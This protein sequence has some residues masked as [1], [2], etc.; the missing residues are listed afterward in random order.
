MMLR[1]QDLEQDSL[2]K[3]DN[4]LCVVSHAALNG[5]APPAPR[6]Y[7][8]TQHPK[9]PTIHG[10]IADSGVV[11][12][13]YRFCVSYRRVFSCS[14]IVRIARSARPLLAELHPGVLS[15][16]TQSGI[17]AFTFST[18]AIIEVFVVAT[19]SQLA[20]KPNERVFQETCQ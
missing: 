13:M 2:C 14:P 3:W 9:C 7:P 12:I 15:T 20:N 16:T 18:T 11:R 10:L 6:A 19:Q 8:V 17:F 1:C 4:F 5:V